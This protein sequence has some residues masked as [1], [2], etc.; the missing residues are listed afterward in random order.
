MTRPDTIPTTARLALAGALAGALAVLGAIT[1]CQHDHHQ[2]HDGAASIYGETFPADG[3]TRATD[4][5]A[6]VQSAAAARADAT[7]TAAHF[8]GR[9]SLNS[10]GRQKLDLM[11]RD[12]DAAAPMVVYLNLPSSTNG[13]APTTASTDAHRQSVRAYL[14]DRGVNDAQLEFR[15]GPNLA[16]SHPAR[17]G[18]RG[19]RHLE[20]TAE[21]PATDESASS[22]GGAANGPPGPPGLTGMTGH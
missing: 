14:V 18:L 7:L 22:T 2:D 17:D 16:Y 5:F 10:L 19:L 21:A 4:R 8:D 15:A 6:Q 1:G 12:D 9:G 20:A 3:E 11:L 13:A